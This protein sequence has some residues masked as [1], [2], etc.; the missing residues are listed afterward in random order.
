MAAKKNDSAMTTYLVTRKGG[1]D[2]KV[3]V[4][5]AWRV[6]FGPL[7]PGS[8]NLASNGAPA[9]R[10]YESEKQ[11]RMVITDVLAFRDMSIKVEEKRTNVKQQVL[12]KDTPGGKKNVIVEG[13]VEEWVNPDA[14][15]ETGAE[16]FRLEHRE[17]DE[18][19]WPGNDHEF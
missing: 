6:T 18:A 11:Q 15:V 8:K 16:F 7:N 17:E 19:A 4:P 9:L 12:S 14:P 10:F 2:Q 3:T 5:A 13:R 1:L